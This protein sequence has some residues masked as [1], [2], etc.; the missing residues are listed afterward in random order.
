MSE[1]ARCS[2]ASGRSACA[3]RRSSGSPR[4]RSS[5]GFAVLVLHARS[6]PASDRV[7][8]C[9]E[10]ADS[11]AARAGRT[12]GDDPRLGAGGPRPEADA[13][14][15][16]ARRNGPGADGAGEGGAAERAQRGDLGA[17]GGVG[18]DGDGDGGGGRAR[19][20]GRPGAA[21]GGAAGGLAGRARAA[22]GAGL[23][24][25]QAHR[26]A[27]P[28]PAPSGAAADLRGADDGGARDAR[29]LAQRGVHRAAHAEVHGL[30]ERVGRGAV[31]GRVLRPSGLPGAVAAVLQAD[32]DGGGLR[33]GVRG[34]PGVPREP[35][36]HLTPRHGVHERGRGDLVDRLA[37]GR[38]G[39]RGALAG[40]RAGGGEG[41]ARRG[42]RSDVRHGAGRCRRSRS[43]G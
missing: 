31:Q 20:T 10:D 16:R 14:R 23:G 34:R 43:R 2:S 7:P 19:E 15:D 8:H 1:G 3:S 4:T 22:G 9:D 32:G 28:G 40:A 13:V 18:G 39:L 11:R 37:R 21:P 27:L 26:L 42:D 29:V 6:R 36:V 17:D 35:V 41:R 38:D 5:G 12:A 30:G 25:R 33:E 24:A